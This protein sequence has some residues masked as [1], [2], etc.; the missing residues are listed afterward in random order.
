MPNSA[1]TSSPLTQAVVGPLLTATMLP[2]PTPIFIETSAPLAVQISR[3]PD[4]GAPS[5]GQ[6][7]L[8]TAVLNPN[9][10]ATYK[11]SISGEAHGTLN[12]LGGNTAEYVTRQQ[13]GTDTVTVEVM[14]TSGATGTASTTFMV[15]GIPPISEEPTFVLVDFDNCIGITNWGDPM[16]SAYL[17]GT[18]DSL[19][20]EYIPET[21]LGCVAKLTYEIANWAAFSLN[22]G[23]RDLSN[24]NTLTFDIK[25]DPA[26]VVPSQMKIELKKSSELLSITCV[27]GISDT[28]QTMS[29]S[30]LDFG[31]AG[32][33]T[34]LPDFKDLSELVFTFEA[35]YGAK[36]V[37][38]LDN[39]T[40]E[41]R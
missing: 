30:F 8:L 24:Y 31:S 29:V 27:T 1:P 38:Y 22:L 36:G 15:A 18:G 26:I 35:R 28:W 33:G 39:I 16:I 13:E 10:P 2:P 34:P 9:Q 11:W 5:S 41:R 19:R 40:F 3:E 4:I 14:T 23:G 25:A 20:E 7:T 32:F 17:P 12:V 21:D 6:R 37:V